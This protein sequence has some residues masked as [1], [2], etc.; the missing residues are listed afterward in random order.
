M[1]ETI[2]DSLGSVD[3]ARPRVLTDVLRRHGISLAKSLGQHFLIDRNH[4]NKIITTSEISKA[5]YTLEVGPGAGVLTQLLARHSAHVTCIELDIRMVAVLQETL[6]GF[7]NSSVIHGDALSTSWQSAFVD[8]HE[9]RFVANIP[10]QITSPLLIKVL[11]HQPKFASATVLVQKEVAERIVAKPG[12]KQFGALTCIA[13]FL[14]DCRIASV[15]PKTVFFTPPKVDS[16]VLHMVPHNRQYGLSVDEFTAIT[17]AAFGQR[18][19]TLRNALR[20]GLG[21]SD[22]RLSMVCDAAGV[23]KEQRA[24]ELTIELFCQMA[25]AARSTQLESKS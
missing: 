4:L 7:T 13:Q 19:K 3:V 1:I 12:T 18:R 22:Q 24:E 17:R 14:C 16:A 21:W 15:V 9:T 25:L 20:D 2:E 23:R 6:A 10:Y 11:E 5:T 8:G